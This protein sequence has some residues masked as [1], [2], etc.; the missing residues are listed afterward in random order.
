MSPTDNAFDKFNDDLKLDPAEKRTAEERHNTITEQLRLLGLVIAGFLQGSLARKTMIKPLR[1]V[2]KVLILSKALAIHH[3]ANGAHA[4]AA[5][6]VDAIRKLYPE[7][8][9][10]IKRHAVTLDFGKDTFCFDMVFAYEFDDGTGDVDIMD[11]KTGGWKRSNTRSLI[12][13]VQDRNKA[14]EETF[15]PLVRELKFL[16]RDK[17]E[18]DLPGLHVESLAYALIPAQCRFNAGVTKVLTDAPSLL[19]SGYADPTGVDKILWTKAKP[20]AREAAAAKFEALAK[21]ALVAEQHT[22]TGEH[23]KAIA[24]WYQIFGEPFPKPDSD[25]RGVLAQAF[26]GA[27]ITTAGTVSRVRPQVTPPVTRAW[28]PR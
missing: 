27:G 12:R 6:M 18:I 2:D 8:E 3:V 19:R 10:E 20:E 17:L 25:S 13:V 11:T 28:A 4:I 23:S 15:V 16:V 9:I 26:T 21:L 1:D 24:T 14:S 22:A 5:I 7:A